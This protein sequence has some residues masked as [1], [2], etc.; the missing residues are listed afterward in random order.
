MTKGNEDCNLSG[1]HQ[2]DSTPRTV[3]QLKQEIDALLELQ[4]DAL[5]RATYVG[6]T[7]EE[8]K[9]IEERRK[10]ITALVDRLAKLKAS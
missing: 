4:S 6:M 10:K 3:E 7:P 8:A 5:K 9:V 2:P 1:G